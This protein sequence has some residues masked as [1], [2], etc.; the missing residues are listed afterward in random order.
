M[1]LSYLLAHMYLSNSAAEGIIPASA[2][3][4]DTEY[5]SSPDITTTSFSSPLRLTPPADADA[6]EVGVTTGGGVGVGA[7]E[8]VGALV[9]SGTGVAVGATAFVAVGSI[10]LV[11]VGSIAWV[12]VGTCV[13][14]GTLVAVGASW[15]PSPSVGVKSAAVSSLSL[16]LTPL[17]SA[18]RSSDTVCCVLPYRGSCLQ[19]FPRIPVWASPPLLH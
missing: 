4:R 10:A 19:K 18:I 7:L 3:L 15:D 16:I 9:G 5:E 12:A 2:I 17:R 11:A 8:G 6:A 13:A 1:R 14:V